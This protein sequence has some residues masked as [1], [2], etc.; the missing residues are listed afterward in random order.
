MGFTP[1]SQR[2]AAAGSSPR[3]AVTARPLFSRWKSTPGQSERVRHAIQVMTTPSRAVV[4][5]RCRYRWNTPNR[6]PVARIATQARRRSGRSARAGPASPVK[7]APRNS[8]SS[9]IA[10]ET[11]IANRINHRPSPSSISATPALNASGTGITFA[12]QKAA[13]CASTNPPATISGTATSDAGSAG[14]TGSRSSSAD[15]RSTRNHTR[16][17]TV[18]PSSTPHCPAIRPGSA[19]SACSKLPR[20]RYSSSVTA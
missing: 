1:S 16:A 14:P 17:A 10:G 3:A 19:S 7:I 8:T 5:M 15:R 20:F 18:T 11:A 13:C 6:R 12:C 9:Q 4:P 2:F